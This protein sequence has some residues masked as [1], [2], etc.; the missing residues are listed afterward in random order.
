MHPEQRWMIKYLIVSTTLAIVGATVAVTDP[1]LEKLGS[2]AARAAA[3]GWTAVTRL[4]PTVQTA[5]TA[6]TESTDAPVS[7]PIPDLA[8]T[9]PTLAQAPTAPVR[10]LALP[11]MARTLGY[12]ETRSF[13]G[14]RCTVIRT[15]PSAA[16]HQLPAAGKS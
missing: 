5:S 2:L 15:I 4:A 9:A 3:P 10:A 11:V 1:S 16:A 12:I 7:T 13:D 8:A 14:Q 6:S